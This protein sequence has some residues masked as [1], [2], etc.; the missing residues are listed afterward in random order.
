[1]H[2]ASRSLGIPCGSE[3]EGVGQY[4]ELQ[5]FVTGTTMLSTYMIDDL[6]RQPPIVLEYVVVL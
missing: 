6:V 3:P 2:G 5:I 1:M 4:L